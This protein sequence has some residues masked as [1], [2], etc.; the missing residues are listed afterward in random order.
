MVIERIKSSFRR[1]QWKLTLSYT[2]V[3]VG[4]LFVVVLILGYLLFSRAFIPIEVYNRVLTPEEW[5]RIIIENDAGLVQSI[6]TQEPI[7]TDLIANLLQEGELTI[8]EHDLLQIGDFHIQI[9]TEARGS[10]ILLDQEGILLGL[11]NP[12]FVPGAVVGQPL[13]RGTF[14][15]LDGALTAALNGEIDPEKVFITLEPHERFYFAIPVTDED[16][17]EVLG[18]VIIY[19][20]HLPTA[21]D[22]PETLTQLLVRSVLILLMAAGVVGT[23]FGAMTARGMVKRLERVSH[24]PA[25]PARC[26]K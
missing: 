13:D 12:S 7:N 16:G 9:R 3:T 15:G 19:I 22:I 23:I 14:P 1:L 20:H 10:T 4:S 6:Y 5:I 18:A 11:S 17:Q 8:T 25:L 21:S 2:A 26:G 24:W